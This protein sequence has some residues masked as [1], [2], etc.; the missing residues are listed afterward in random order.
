M[1]LE[2]LNRFKFDG[3]ICLTAMDDPTAKMLAENKNVTVIKP[4]KMA[5]N[6]IVDALPEMRER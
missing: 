1:L 3:R 4:L 6:R 5:A 2:T